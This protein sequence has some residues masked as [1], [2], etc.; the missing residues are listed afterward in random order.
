MVNMNMKIMHINSAMAKI[1]R[2]DFTEN[3]NYGFVRVT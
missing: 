2:L 3:K 1:T